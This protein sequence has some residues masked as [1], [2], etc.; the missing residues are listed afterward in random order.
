MTSPRLLG[1]KEITQHVL[2]KLLTVSLAFLLAFG[3]LPLVGCQENKRDQ[4]KTRQNDYTTHQDADPELEKA[5]SAAKARLDQ[6]NA[7]LTEVRNMG[8]D[9]SDLNQ[10]ILM[11]QFLF[12]YARTPEEYMGITDSAA[13]WAMVVINGCQAKK[14]SLLAEQEQENRDESH[15]VDESEPSP[16]PAVDPYLR[17]KIEV[18]FKPDVTEEEVNA[19]GARHHIAYKYTWGTHA[20]YQ[21]DVRGAIVNLPAGMS[22][23]EAVTAFA[24]E[25]YV[26]RATLIP[27][28][29]TDGGI[30]EARVEEMESAERVTGE[31]LVSLHDNAD[32]EV[33]RVVFAR[34]GFAPEQYERLVNLIPWFIVSFSEE[35]RDIR[36]VFRGFFLDDGVKH[37]EPNYILHM[38]D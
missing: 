9:T 11:A 4:D 21:G 23:E 12:H 36:R 15:K 7:A 26:E 17:G 31:V 18:A 27:I 30:L 3:L 20:H 25:P 29:Y 2:R 38:I 5:E 19:M 37:A 10:A 24:G 28:Q 16:Q 32:D 14:E 8:I 22:E 1:T 13:Y 35:D 33:A 34:H 6:A